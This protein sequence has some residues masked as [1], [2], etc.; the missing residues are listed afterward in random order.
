MDAL[1]T[2][3]PPTVA[4]EQYLGRFRTFL[5]S[6]AQ[7]SPP[8]ITQTRKSA[9]SQF[10]EMGLPTPRHEEWRF[11][12]VSALAQLPFHPVEKRPRGCKPEDFEPF[13]VPH[14]DAYRL[15]FIDGHHCPELSLLPETNNGLVLG[16]LATMLETNP[17]EIEKHLG[18]YA[19][20]DHNPFTALN[21]AFFQDGAFVSVPAGE[22]VHVPVH[23]VFVATAHQPGAAQH[24]RNLILADKQSTLTVLES[25]VAL[26]EAPSITNSV[27][28]LVVGPEARVEHCRIQNESLQAFHFAT[29]HAQQG[30]GS[31]WRSHSI[32]MG[33][34]LARHD[35]GSTLDGEG[36]ECLL[37]GL[38]LGR[39]KQLVDHHTVVNHAKPHCESHEFYHG[40]LDDASHGVFNGKIFVQQ[41]AQKTNAKQTNRNLLLSEDAVVD[42]KP[43]LEIFADDVKCT[44]GATVGQLNQD[45][46]FYLRARGIGLEDARR[47]LVHAFA[48]QIVDRIS[49]E[50]VRANL[51]KQLAQRFR[52][53]S[54]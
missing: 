16:S 36:A 4:V 53:S 31:L 7:S 40:I 38:Y 6:A 15:V 48:R 45:A 26:A 3:P 11:T 42:T 13:W 21:T 25:Y 2:Q 14:L 1:A 17:R 12:N 41:D 34:A 27:T 50:A 54:L 20:Y 37:N 32:S 52:G 47:M 18:Q 33:A 35:I 23:L 46:I 10:V 49:V 9:I 29:V 51:D 39:D 28:E 30:R 44:H 43:Q 5:K 8:W 22:T 24:P 19:S